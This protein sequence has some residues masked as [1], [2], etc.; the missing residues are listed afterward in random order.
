M[1][2]KVPD[3]VQWVNAYSCTYSS[4]AETVRQVT[5]KVVVNR[6]VMETFPRPQ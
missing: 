4:K 5:Q 1:T 3:S 2:E 6:C